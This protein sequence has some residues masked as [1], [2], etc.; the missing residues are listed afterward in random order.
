MRRSPRAQDPSRLR[1]TP[2]LRSSRS[3]LPRSVER[4]ARCR[5][6]TSVR[7]SRARACRLLHF[8]A[9]DLELA[10]EVEPVDA[11]PVLD[12]LAGSGEMLHQV[13]PGLPEPD[14]RALQITED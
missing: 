7:G 11:I 1:A 14:E 5:P 2:S 3:V 9:P 4:S 8:D 12:L 13:G 10:V 6:R